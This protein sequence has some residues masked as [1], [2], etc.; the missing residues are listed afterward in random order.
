MSKRI[1]YLEDE[2]DVITLVRLILAQSNCEVVG[3]S[4]VPAARQLLEESQFDL[5]LIDIM[6]P[7]EN[8]W[9]F[10]D[11]VEKL[12]HLHDVPKV[13]LT[14]RVPTIDP[15]TGKHRLETDPRLASFLIKPF[16]PQTLLTVVRK[17]L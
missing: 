6:M 5:F 1:L 9:D 8:G 12:T 2:V 15:M 17:H 7:G 13:V 10:L 11:Y 4:S 3:A 16:S 14:A